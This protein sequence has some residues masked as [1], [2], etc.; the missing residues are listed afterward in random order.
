MRI[1]AA[2]CVFGSYIEASRIGYTEDIYI[3]IVYV[4]VIFSYSLI[5][6][7]VC[8]RNLM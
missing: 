8:S 6:S 1:R 7:F 3:H 5:C 4:C 2:S